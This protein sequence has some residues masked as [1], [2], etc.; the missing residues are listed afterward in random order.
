MQ[1]MTVRGPISPEELGATMPHEHVLFDFTVWYQ[2]PKAGG[3]K[4]G[5]GPV[6]LSE[7]GALFRN[8]FLSRDNLFVN[9]VE[10]QIEE[11]NDF[12]KAGGATIVDVT[13]VGIGRD[14][15]AL[16]RISEAT[17]L[18]I[19]MGCG[20]Y[21]NDCHPSYVSEMGID[22]LADIMVKEID[23]GVDGTGIRPGIIGEIG[24]SDPITDCEEKVV[25]AAARAQLR[26]GLPMNIHPFM[27]SRA[28]LRALD[29]LKEEGV[30]LRR[31]VMSH[32]DE[33]TIN[34]KIDLERGRIAA[35]S[36]AFIEYDTWG[37]EFYYAISGIA[38]KEPSDLD[39]AAAMAQ[40]IREG[41]LSQLLLSQ[42]VWLKICLKR[43]GGWGYD[44]ILTYGVR[45]LREAGVTDEQIR[46]MLV[47]NPRRALSY[48]P[49]S[50]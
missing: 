9:D 25:R 39:R 3:P 43:Y 45:Y 33:H 7:F 13:N 40:L 2:P 46:V 47:D 35:A 12:K 42:D 31:V 37:N 49:A 15:L 41:Y 10:Q 21:V 30:D 4:I 22:Q 44:N 48:E 19:V 20:F 5:A 6:Q 8:P 29:F 1:A 50:A 17:G 24:T 11:L 16:R 27:W 32:M 34:G 26:T 23:E 36:G 28:G 38:K 18:N 14:P